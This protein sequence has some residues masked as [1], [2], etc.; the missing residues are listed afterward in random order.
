MS[1]SPLRYTLKA[2]SSGSV[3]KTR[4]EINTPLPVCTA[5]V[6]R[7]SFSTCLP[8]RGWIGE[9][10]LDELLDEELELLELELDEELLELDELLDEELLELEELLLELLELDCSGSVAPVPPPQAV[11]MTVDDKI[12]RPK[13]LIFILRGTP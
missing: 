6:P 4:Q 10:L 5:T 11:K 2:V 9:P 3:P 1:S 12:L 8:S 7:L 13:I